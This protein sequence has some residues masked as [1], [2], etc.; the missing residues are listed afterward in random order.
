MLTKEQMTAYRA[1]PKRIDVPELGECFI[2][3]LS[4]AEVQDGMRIGEKDI[5]ASRAY[6]VAHSLCDEVGERIFADKDDAAQ[7]PFI[8]F[9]AIYNESM[10]HNRLRVEDEEKP[11]KN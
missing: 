4:E 10:L 6:A 11:P 3:L 5:A 8:A 9:M 1:K 7:L 2:R